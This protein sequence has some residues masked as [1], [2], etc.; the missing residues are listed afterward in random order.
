MP[1]HGAIIRGRSNL[2]AHVQGGSAAAP[3]CISTTDAHKPAAPTPT[4]KCSRE[5]VPA[6]RTP[7]RRAAVGRT[8]VA[9][10]PPVGQGQRHTISIPSYRGASVEADSVMPGATFFACSDFDLARSHELAST[11]GLDASA[12]A[13]TPG[14]Y[15]PPSRRSP[16][17][18]PKRAADDGF[19]AGAEKES[20]VGR[21][22]RPLTSSAH[23][24]TLP[25]IPYG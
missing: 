17:L 9:L 21:C 14:A 16:S 22:L 11:L 7:N 10:S 19:I 18:A 15:P 6:P 2:G 12:V 24:A 20:T 25:A 4:Y 3:G 8:R 5:A 23:S 13:D 1:L